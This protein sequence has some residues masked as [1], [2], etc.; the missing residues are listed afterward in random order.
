MK[1]VVGYYGAPIA[2]L[3][4]IVFLQL[5]SERAQALPECSGEREEV[6]VICTESIACL[7]GTN[8][9]CVTEVAS[10]AVDKCTSEDA[11]PGHN[12]VDVEGEQQCATR[13]ECAKNLAGTACIFGDPLGNVKVSEVG[14]GG[15]CTLPG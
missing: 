10:A 13:R 3:A 5:F 15:D 11:L 1:S 7:I 9:E 8:P 4:A 12:C 2:A 6:N 14:D